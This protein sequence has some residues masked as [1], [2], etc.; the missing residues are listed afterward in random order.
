MSAPASP[1]RKIKVVTSDMHLSAGRFVD[2]L[3]NP[4]EDFFFD[5]EFC[6]FLD[7][8]STGIYGDGCEVELIL[9]GDVL[10]FLNVQVQG[11]WVDVVTSDIAVEKLVNILDGHREVV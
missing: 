9:N 8:F 2:G 7:Y 10:D 5:H 11:E 1:P 4:Y 3:P 6:E